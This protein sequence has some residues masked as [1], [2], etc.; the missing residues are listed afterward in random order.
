MFILSGGFM[1]KIGFENLD[2]YKL[3]RKFNKEMYQIT[4]DF[5]KS[6]MYGIVSQMRRASVSI[7]ANIAEGSGRKGKAEQRQFYNIS[8]GSLFEC[9]ALLDIAKDLDYISFE[10]HIDLKEKAVDILAKL[11]GLLKYT[12]R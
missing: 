5:P 3:A 8:K 2:V 10:K 11:N 7:N 6:E 4:K 9:I 1:L 12:N